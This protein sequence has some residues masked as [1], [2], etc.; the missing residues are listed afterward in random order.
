MKGKKEGLVDLVK[1]DGKDREPTDKE[2]EEIE[3]EG[4]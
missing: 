1:T 3:K 2:L 4:K